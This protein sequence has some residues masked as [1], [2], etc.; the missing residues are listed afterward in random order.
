MTGP[1][2]PALLPVAATV[3]AGGATWF[4]CVRPARRRAKDPS[5]GCCAAPAATLEEQIRATRTELLHLRDS[6]TP[7]A[8]PSNGPET[9]IR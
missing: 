5:A 2:L 9:L 4:C 7:P 3:L 8:A 1:F 6:A